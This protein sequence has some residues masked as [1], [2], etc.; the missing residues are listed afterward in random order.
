[1][2]FYIYTFV[3]MIIKNIYLFVNR[4]IYCFYYKAFLLFLIMKYFMIN[5]SIFIS[6]INYIFI[7]IISDMIYYAN[8]SYLY[9]YIFFYTSIDFLFFDPY[10]KILILKDSLY[11]SFRFPIEYYK[12]LNIIVII[13]SIFKNIIILLKKN[14]MSI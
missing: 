8:L 7:Y 9:Q 13:I 12:R 1:M 2:L 6:L 4:F 11:S 5:I 14:V 3:F 10:S